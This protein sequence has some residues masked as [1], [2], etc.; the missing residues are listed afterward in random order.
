MSI[1]NTPN[2]STNPIGIAPVPNIQLYFVSAA[3][4][5]FANNAMNIAAGVA[6]A[7]QPIILWAITPGTFSWNSAWFLTPTG[8]IICPS[9]PLIV[10]GV[11]S[12]TVIACIRNYSDPSQY[13]TIAGTPGSYT[14]VNKQT[15][16]AITAPDTQVVYNS[17]SI[18]PNLSTAAL[19]SPPSPGQLWA[20]QAADE[21]LLP[22][23]QFYIQSA[24]SGYVHSGTNPYMLAAA[25]SGAV[26]EQWQPGAPSQLWAFNGDGTI[27]SVLDSGLLSVLLP[28]DGNSTDQVVLTGVS[29][30]YAQQWSYENNC[31]STNN[32]AL[33]LNVN[34]ADQSNGA[35]VIAWHLNSSNDMSDETWYTLSAQSM[36]IGEW[37]YLATEVSAGSDAPPFVLTVSGTVAKA[38]AG[39]VIEPL[40]PGAVNQ[41]WQINANGVIFS[42]LDSSMALTASSNGKQQVTIEP[43]QSNQAWQQWYRYSNGT[44]AVGTSGNVWFL[45]VDDGTATAGTEVITFTFDT[46]SNGVWNTIPYIPEPSGQWFTIQNSLTPPGAPATLLLTVS[47]D[48][49][50]EA[51]PPLGGYVLPQGQASINQLWRKMFNGNI[52]SAVNPNLVLT[53]ASAGGVVTLAGLQPGSTNQQ[54]F[55]DYSQPLAVEGHKGDV[56]C[57]VLQN[58]GQNQ[59]LWAAGSP[60]GSI[61]LQPAAAINDTGNQLW[62]VLPH[63]PT[64]GQSTTI[65]N[66]G[67]T[68]EVAGLFLSL[69]ASATSGNFQATVNEKSDIAALSMWQFQFP[70]YI[71]SGTDP[72]VVLSLEVDPT[73]TPQNPTYTNNVVAYPRQPDVQLFQLWSVSLEGLIV[74]QYSGQA[75]TASATTA[76]SNAITTALSDSPKTALQLWDFSPGVALQT[77]LQQSPVP[78][79]AWTSGQAI[80]YKAINQELGL[81]DG[82]RVQY[83]NLAAPLSNYQLQMNLILLPLVNDGALTGKTKPSKQ[84]LEDWISVVTQL[85]KELTAATAVQLLFAQATALHLSLS[86]A[87]AMTLSELVTGCELPKGLQTKIQPQKKKKSWI[88][89]LIEGLAYTSLNAAG[90]FVGD[91]EAGT[92][93]GKFVKDGLPCIANLMATG[94]TTSQG[95]QQTKASAMTAKY[96]TAFNKAMQNMYNYEMTV[97]EM[98]QALL[99]EF[100][101]IGSTLGQIEALILS[102]WGKLGAVYNMTRSVGTMSSLFWPSTMTP[103]QANQLLGGYTIGVLQTLMPA[104]TGYKISATMHAN[105]GSLSPAGLQSDGSFVE[106]NDDGTQNIYT[107]T[108]NQQM[109]DVVWA[110]GVDPISFFRGINGWNLTREYIV[111][112]GGKDSAPSSFGASAIVNIQNFTNQELLITISSFYGLLGNGCN[113]SGSPGQSGALEANTTRSITP[114][115]LQ[116]VAGTCWEV[117]EGSSGPATWYIFGMYG[118][119]VIT[120]NNNADSVGSISI[121]NSYNQGAGYN[122]NDPVPPTYSCSVTQSTPYIVTLD[123]V[124]SQEMYLFNISIKIGS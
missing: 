74:N 113:F 118:T 71:V 36:P 104:N 8:M 60:N 43:V 10:L 28:N 107:T 72:D 122:S 98:Q 95:I 52:V 4:P 44:I 31:L 86:Q 1:S 29:D 46:S 106:N 38:G 124:V 91:P 50:L 80:A 63:A 64:F 5:V 84:E 115:G 116:T 114:Y 67:G 102:D 103:M 11:N 19:N 70:G 61:T 73:S 85:N 111:W 53:G 99:N 33:Y 26:I 55:W 100:E 35:I 97:L 24:L 88:G 32:N 87:Q 89:D 65:R 30:S 108:V 83:A 82:I 81:P 7:G 77:T 93:A 58:L 45:N 16:E 79:P 119:L 96:E 68:D 34:N 39:V 76:P 21:V 25:A 78:F 109:M 101:A 13:W 105:Q 6:G 14:I 75:L 92:M 121:N 59:V 56:P 12:S 22:Y 69:P 94:F 27:A 123:T 66:V 23:N 41:L 20:M 37:F 120:D 49:N 3:S 90:L 54:W 18:A 51:S 9:D 17:N 62:Y 112:V 110:N 48:G 117:E 47:A 57:G 2:L 42:A 40:Q 15:Q